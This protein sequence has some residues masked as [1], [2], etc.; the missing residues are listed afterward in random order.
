MPRG[1]Y[2]TKKGKI[3]AQ[4][5]FDVKAISTV[6]IEKV[7]PNGW[8]PKE[9][10]TPE[11]RSIRDSI[12]AKGLIGYILV[13]DH[14]HT[15]GYYEIIDGE[16]RWTA[17]KSLKHHEIPIYNAGDVDEKD[18]KELTI[19]FQEQVPFKKE[20]EAFLVTELVTEFGANELEVPYNEMEI[21]DLAKLADHDFD[22]NGEDSSAGKKD[23]VNLDGTVSFT[24]KLP[25]SD[26]DI[27]IEALQQYAH[28]NG[29]DITNALVMICTE[30]RIDQGGD[31]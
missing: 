12:K 27:V 2:K 19:W 29:V 21:A 15:P 6:D 5:E 8:N 11:Y 14:P 10:D 20:L 22:E 26:Y 25:Q 28:D 31:E 7:V 3:M 18:A 16:Q 17:C 30:L 4:R 23:G 24:A 9:K 1:S 13:R